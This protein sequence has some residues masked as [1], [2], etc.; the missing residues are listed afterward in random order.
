MFAQKVLKVGLFFKGF[1]QEE[2]F[3]FASLLMSIK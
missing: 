1:G 3:V 2:N